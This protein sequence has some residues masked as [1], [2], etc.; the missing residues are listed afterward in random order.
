[1]T[2]GKYSE[3][4]CAEMCAIDDAAL[5]VLCVELLPGGEGNEGGGRYALVAVVVVAARFCSTGH[6]PDRATNPWLFFCPWEA[7]L[8]SSPI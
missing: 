8:F 2:G 5:N 1:M 4:N 6:G 3:G 7:L